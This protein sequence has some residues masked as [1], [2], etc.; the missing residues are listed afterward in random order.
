MP[1]SQQ[2]ARL[3]LTIDIIRLQATLSS[4]RNHRLGPR[5][6]NSDRGVSFKM[7]I[8]Y[9]VNNTAEMEPE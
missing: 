5:C 4:P 2:Q 1:D 7:K 9:L 3:F 6:S 8:N